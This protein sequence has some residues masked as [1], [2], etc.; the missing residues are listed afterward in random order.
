MKEPWE[1][2]LPWIAGGFLPLD[3]FECPLGGFLP[4]IVDGG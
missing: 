4:W 2:I 3:I 1:L